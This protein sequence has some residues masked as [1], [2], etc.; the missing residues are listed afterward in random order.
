MMSELI[1]EIL[2]ALLS[3]QDGTCNEVSVTRETEDRTI[4][5]R[6][7]KVGTQLRTSGAWGTCNSCHSWKS[8]NYLDEAKQA[9]S[10][11]FHV[12][13]GSVDIDRLIQEIKVQSAV[14]DFQLEFT[15]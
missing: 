12:M 9:L 3:L 7:D 1:K 4:N 8:S 15:E 10:F 13:E 2:R 5:F 6:A 11:G 14:D